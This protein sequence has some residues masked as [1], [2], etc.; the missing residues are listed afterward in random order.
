MHICKILIRDYTGQGSSSCSP[1]RTSNS[2]SP[3]ELDE[4]GFEVLHERKAASRDLAMLCTTLDHSVE[5]EIQ[6]RQ[7]GLFR[8][9]LLTQRLPLKVDS[10]RRALQR[11]R[12]LFVKPF[13][14]TVV[15]G[16]NLVHVFF[17]FV[18]RF[19]VSRFFHLLIVFI[20]FRVS[21]F[22]RLVIVSFAFLILHRG[23]SLSV[24]HIN[25]VSTSDTGRK[26]HLALRNNNRAKNHFLWHHKDD[27][28][29]RNS[30]SE[31]RWQLFQKFQNKGLVVE[32]MRD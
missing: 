32:S 24:H 5:L 10:W 9:E 11:A 29:L 23:S 16:E 19:R 26:V 4:D 27:D 31:L 14:A 13:F 22:F 2:F 3:R 6:K 20:S 12:F 1:H 15:I 18:I 8:I 25:S 28:H 17:H 30:R 21:R 7:R